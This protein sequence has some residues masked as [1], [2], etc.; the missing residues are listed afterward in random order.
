MRG[1]CRTAP[2]SVAL[3]HA[4]RDRPV[5]RP[6]E[7]AEF[8]E[9]HVGI[10]RR[11]ELRDPFTIRVGRAARRKAR[12]RHLDDLPYL[13][14]LAHTALPAVVAVELHRREVLD[15]VRTVRP[16][17][18]E[19]EHDEAL[20]GFSYGRAGDP[21][22]LTQRPLGGQLA[23]G[24]Q[25]AAGDARR[26]GLADLLRDRAP[27][28]GL[29]L[30]VAHVRA[31][32]SSVKSSAKRRRSASMSSGRMIASCSSLPHSRA[33]TSHITSN[34]RPSGSAA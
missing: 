23:P 34:S 9:S 30:D 21:E 27:R 24:F 1:P 17:L 11:G 19:T 13:E 4:A 33:G 12:D 8:L 20:D 3:P 10:E 22:L 26:D 15:N 2:A 14:Q 32:S 18:D 7:A 6:V 25:L 16:P 29:E 5:E 28:D 31:A